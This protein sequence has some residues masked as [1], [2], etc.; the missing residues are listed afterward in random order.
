MDCPELRALRVCRWQLFGSHSF[1]SAAMSDRVRDKIWLAFV[2]EVENV[3]RVRPL[4]LLWC[5]REERG[6]QTNRLHF[7]S[8]LGGIPSR[9]VHPGLCFQLMRVWERCGGGWCRMRVFNSDSETPDCAIGYTVKDLSGADVYESAKFGSNRVSQLILSR[10]VER[11]VST[12]GSMTGG[13]SA[14][15]EKCPEN[16]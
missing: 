1:K 7:H 4:H 11:V 9:R 8:L 15:H 10:S 3:T 13:V 5:R 16:E 14:N 2:R 6:E 12:A